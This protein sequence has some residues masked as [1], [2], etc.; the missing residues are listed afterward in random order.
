M[1]HPDNAGGIK[2]GLCEYFAIYRQQIVGLKLLPSQY[3]T[4]LA[5]QDMRLS[6]PYSQ[7]Q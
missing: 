3:C 2:D 6:L 5:G 7:K 4:S 1:A